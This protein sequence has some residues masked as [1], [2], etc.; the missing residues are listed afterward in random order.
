MKM[1]ESLVL[2]KLRNGEKV[3]SFKI[4]M[5][6]A[7]AV[8]IAA[9]AGFDCLWVDQEHI[10]QDWSILAAQI[11][12]AKAHQKDVVVRVPRGSYSDY[13]KP[14]ELD[15]A[16]IMVPHVMGVEDAKKVIHQVRF[17][18]VGMRPIDGGNADGAYTG[19]DFQHYL[20][21]ANTSR[22]VIF[23][24]EDPEA[25]ECLE[26]IAALEGFD[27]LFFGPGDFSQ[28]IGA[29][30]Q[31]DHPKIKEARRRVAEVAGKYGKFA[32]TTGGT[33][34]LPE[35]YA[36]GYQFVSIGADVV[37]LTQYCQKLIAELP[38]GE[39]SGETNSYYNPSK[40]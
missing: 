4:N 29:P 20:K 26:E 31:W 7:R 30:G 35:L 37:G 16:G 8:E 1:K 18:P 9:I 23:Q 22:F 28:G 25:L 21:E 15:A 27:M 39:V 5:A 10:G 11:W 13:V 3:T 2:N 33:A 24:I 36:M 38:S 14:L 40:E 32:G 34:Q 19:M 6:D 17:H 12:A